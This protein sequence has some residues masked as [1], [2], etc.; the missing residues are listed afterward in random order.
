MKYLAIVFT[1]LLALVGAA[2][3]DIPSSIRFTLEHEQGASPIVYYFTK[4]EN[5]SYPIVVL[6][7]GS[8]VK[9]DLRSVFYIRSF[10]APR[11]EALN[12]GYLTVEK[13]G[14]DGNETNEDEF[15]SHYSRTQRLQDHLKVI[16]HFEESPPPG[17][18]GKFVFIG[19]SE[20]G[21]LVTDLSILCPNT[22]AT[23]NWSGAGDWPW[24]D[25]FWQFFETMK[26]NSFWMRLLDSIPRWFPFSSDIPSSR[27]EYDALVRHI[28]QN[29]TTEQYLGGM[30][31]YYHADAFQR[32]SPQYAK[33]HA[34]FL[35][36]VGTNDS[37]LASCDQFVKK[38]QEAGAPIT[39]LR[40]EDMDHYIRLR[41]DVIDQSFAWL[42]EQL[43]YQPQ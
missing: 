38:A 13:W 41:P 6:C 40:V 5:A 43:S 39:Y 32:P 23:I 16:R 3:H 4:P 7:D 12:V 20:G 2:P 34:P 35:V 14:I 42:K 26:Q 8:E 10:F 27:Q 36:V 9:G 22:L 29:P 33:I 19:V 37:I 15:W 21:P 28:I 25:E 30:S 24:A 18:N 17:W 31:Y 1:L 11:V